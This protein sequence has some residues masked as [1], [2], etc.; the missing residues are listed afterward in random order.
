MNTATS[1]TLIDTTV[2]PISRAPSSAA[3][4]ARAVLDMAVDVLHHHDGVVDHETDRDGHRHQRQIV[5]AEAEH[6]HHGGRAGERERH[7]DGRDQ[8]RAQVAQEQRITSTTSAMVSASVNS[9][10]ATEARIVWVRST[11]VSIFMPGGISAPSCGI[12]A[13]TRHGLDHVCA[14]LLEHQQDHALARAI[15]VAFQRRDVVVL[16]PGTAWPTSRT[17]TGAPLR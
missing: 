14:R 17:R 15:L 9:T 7:H 13:F 3:W 8:C 10:S 11:M 4:T 6:V 2:K 5:E 1:E 12:A 16:R